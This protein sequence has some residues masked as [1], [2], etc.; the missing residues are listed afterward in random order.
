MKNIFHSIVLWAWLSSVPISQGTVT[1]TA[2][3]LTSLNEADLIQ[4]NV[5]EV[6]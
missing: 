3:A 2:R 5:L 1:G 6:L 4:V